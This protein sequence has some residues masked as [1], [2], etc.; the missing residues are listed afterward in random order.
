MSKTRVF[1]W[2]SCVS[3]D[4][5][6]R[7]DTSQF[8]LVDYVARQSAISAGSTPVTSVS[9]P[10]LESPFQQRMVT[11][12]FSSELLTRLRTAAGHTDLI[13]FDLTD[14][15][16]GV[17]VLPDGSVITRS[18]EL[19]QSGAED[20]LPSGAR[21]VPFGSREHFR[22]WTS[23][24]ET[25]ARHSQDV[26]VTIPIVILDVAWASMS[27][28]GTEAPLSFGMDAKTANPLFRMYA[29][30][31]ATALQAYTL[32]ISPSEAVSGADHPWG[33]A[34]FHY[35]EPVYSKLVSALTDFA[36]SLAASRT[37]SPSVDA[38][39]TQETAEQPAAPQEPTRARTA[40]APQA[41]SADLADLE[42]LTLIRN[43]S[44]EVPDSRLISKQ[45]TR[46]APRSHW[47]FWDDPDNVGYKPVARR[48]YVQLHE[49]AIELSER[50]RPEGHRFFVHE[51]GHLM[52]DRVLPAGRK[53]DHRLLLTDRDTHVTFDRDAE[54][55]WLAGSRHREPIHIAGRVGVAL[56][57][58]P[59]NWGSFITR[60]VP[61]A[62]MLRRLGCDKLLAYCR[63]ERQREMLRLVGWA[64]DDI[65]DYRPGARYRIE[66]SV[67]P[68]EPTDGLYLSPYAADLLGTMGGKPANRNI[69]ISRRTGIA[70]R[71][72]RVCLNADEVEDAMASLGLEPVVPDELTVSQQIETF[73]AAN[74]VVG[75]S[76]AGM[77]NTVFCNP[78]TVIVDIE[79]QPNWLHAHNN[80]FASTGMR[81]G[82]FFG[83]PDPGAS[84][85]HKP[86]TINVPRLTAR[87]AG[88]LAG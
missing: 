46:V 74:L 1:I 37:H 2:G 59:S 87:V 54:Q 78:G 86:Y 81:H 14:E 55:F 71:S 27:E 38:L 58:E 40:D 34:P 84:G 8:E 11:G 88:L 7:L 67:V 68:A 61:K 77:F 60:I 72:K 4:T 3:R 21:H 32:S 17:Y 6:E 39:P 33:A 64:D 70:A 73:A 36:D 9:P 79:S 19:I 29:A 16:L 18:I 20:H 76:G 43:P 57:V 23:A 50:W 5:F 22:F 62:I 25:V 26:L 82:F 69:Y 31:A 47:E 63:H 85:P 28:N 42:P 80:L 45:N 44:L 49:F 48:E 53:D 24:I 52:L 56:S 41:P 10:V 15:R 12:D 35:A 30:S 65:I 13:L 66:S 51:D 75:P 83:K